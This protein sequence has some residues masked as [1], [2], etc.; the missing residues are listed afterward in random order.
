[1]GKASLFNSI[2]PTCKRIKASE[3]YA[4]FSE[5]LSTSLG[6]WQRCT[7]PAA[8]RP[9]GALAPPPGSP[10]WALLQTEGEPVLWVTAVSQVS[11]GLWEAAVQVLW[12]KAYTWDM[13]C[14][15][16]EFPGVTS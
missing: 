7:A 14:L 8:L 13:F 11:T 5:C 3:T 10:A 12:G 9:G 16:E 2:A 6:S 1:M 4:W 15:S